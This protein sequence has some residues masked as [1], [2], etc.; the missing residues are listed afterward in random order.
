MVTSNKGRLPG[1]RLIP[2]RYDHLVPQLLYEPVTVKVR[3]FSA[4]PLEEDA[5]EVYHDNGKD[6]YEVTLAPED[7]PYLLPYMAR[8]RDGTKDGA[9]F[10]ASDLNTPALTFGGRQTFYPDASRIFAEID[11][12]ISGRTVDGEGS[13]LDRKADF[14][15]VRVL[16]SGGYTKRGE[17]SGVDFFPYRPEALRKAARTG[18]LARAANL[19]QREIDS[20]KYGGVV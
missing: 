13:I 11:R 6:Y 2:G 1:D 10:E 18:D 3:K 4:H 19:V 7:G 16:P 9:P 5:V 15:F 17:V 14:D 12:T 20:G 8:R